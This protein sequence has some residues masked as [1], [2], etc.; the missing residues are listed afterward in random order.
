MI[1]VEDEE[2]FKKSG[3]RDVIAFAS[4]LNID[5]YKVIANNILFPIKSY[6]IEQKSHGWDY[7]IYRQDEQHT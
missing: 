5:Q 1:G 6:Q 7:W 3:D 4:L 2:E